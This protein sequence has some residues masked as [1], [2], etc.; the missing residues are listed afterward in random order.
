MPLDQSRWLTGEIQGVRLFVVKATSAE[1]VK[2][3]RNVIKRYSDSY[4]SPQDRD[5]TQDQLKVEPDDDG[6]GPNHRGTY[7]KAYT[8]LHPEIKW[9]HRGQGRYLPAAT[10]HALQMQT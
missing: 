7:S 8:M 9:V 5:Q 2:L 3:L 10:A 1:G 6:D 4:D